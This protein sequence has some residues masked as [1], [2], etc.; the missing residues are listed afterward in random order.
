MLE[1]TDGLP[2][3]LDHT[4]DDLKTYQEQ[5]H[6]TFVMLDDNK[7][8]H[9]ATMARRFYYLATPYSHP[10]SV[11]VQHRHDLALRAAAT[12]WRSG[13]RVFCPIVHAHPINNAMA[14][15]APSGDPTGWGWEYH[16]EFD[17]HMVAACGKVIV[18]KMDGW[19]QS[20]GVT[21]EID[22]A[23][24]HKLA[25]FYLHPSVLNPVV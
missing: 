8:R 23:K 15:H 20:V 19:D 7:Q 6:H 11:V 10:D 17:L 16:C 22:F 21:A 1:A 18:L 14:N 24:K 3:G 4:L 5:V 13:I 25:I 9:H 12:L 2:T